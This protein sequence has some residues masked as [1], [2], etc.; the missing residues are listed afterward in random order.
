M[1]KIN[2]ETIDED[3]FKLLNF[4]SK[5]IDEIVSKFYDIDKHYFSISIMF[6]NRTTG[7][8]ISYEADTVNQYDNFFNENGEKIKG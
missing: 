1:L 4:I 8:T 3:D 2:D 7:K 5:K 6:T